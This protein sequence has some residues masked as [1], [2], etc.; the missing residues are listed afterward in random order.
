MILPCVAVMPLFA[1]VGALAEA[2]PAVLCAVPEVVFGLE[3]VDWSVVI[4]VSSVEIC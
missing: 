4:C 1:E 2:V 3:V